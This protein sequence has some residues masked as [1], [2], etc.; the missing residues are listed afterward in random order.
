MCAI[1]IMMNSIDRAILLFFNS[2]ARHSSTFDGFFSL[3]ADNMLL[4]GGVFVFLFWYLWFRG[5]PEQANDRE[6]LLLGTITPL[7]AVFVSRVVAHSFPLR[8]RPLRDPALHFHLPY[9]MNPD[10]LQGWSSFPSDHAAFF[11]ALAV[12]ILFVSW[13][14]GV[15]AIAYSTLVICV[16]RIYLGIH[17]PTDMI[18]GA[19]IGSGVSCLTLITRARRFLTQRVLRYLDIN[20]SVSYGCLSVLTY[21]LGTVCEPVPP[22]IRFASGVMM[23]WLA[24][25]HLRHASLGRQSMAEPLVVLIVAIGIIALLSFLAWIFVVMKTNEPKSSRVHGRKAA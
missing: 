18:A 4:K 20:P 6:F 12:V 19:L 15:F 14:A 17:Y 16:P 13:R 7:F 8:E 22:L 24:L 2:F 3:L 11:F 23:S 9:G 25:G 10:V 21:L 5:N 1:P